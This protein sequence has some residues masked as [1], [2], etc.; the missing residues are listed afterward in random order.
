MKKVLI[1]D[2]SSLAR[3]VVRAAIASML[4]GAEFTEAEDGL[5]AL[6]TLTTK[7]FDLIFCDLNMPSLDGHGL[8]ARMRGLPNHKKT[9]VIILSSLVNEAKSAQLKA[10]GANFVIK[11]PFSP[12][13]IKEGLTAVGL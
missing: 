8:L 10:A 13:Q 5:A 6:R 7:S 4:A 3:Q 1:V 9:P 12:Q 2:D 11:K